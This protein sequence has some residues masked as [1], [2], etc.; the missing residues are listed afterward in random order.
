[1]L[2]LKPLFPLIFAAGFPFPLAG[3]FPF[4]LDFA[5]LALYLG[6]IAV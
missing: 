3:G 1:L 4:T 6:G 2:S 5:A